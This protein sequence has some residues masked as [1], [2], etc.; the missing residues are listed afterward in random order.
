MIQ[1]RLTKSGQRRYRVRYE[2]PAG[3][4]A[5]RTFAR[6]ED[7]LVYE[8]FV[9]DRVRNGD[10]VIATREQRQRTVASY[11]EEAIRYR[12]LEART[13][14]RYLELWRLHVEPT[15]GRIPIAKVSPLDIRSWVRR[16]LTVGLAK[17][18][19]A[20]CVSVLSLAMN[21]AVE[22]GV[23]AENPTRGCRPKLDRIPPGRSLTSKGV[24]QLLSHLTVEDRPLYLLGS[25]CG[26]RFGELAGLQVGD[27]DVVTQRV[28]IQRA[29]I[30]LRGKQQVKPY[31]KGGSE[32][33]RDIGVP[34]Q[35]IVELEPLLQGRPEGDGSSPTDSAGPSGTRPHGIVFSRL[36]M[37]PAS[38][39]VP[40][41]CSAV[42]PPRS[43]FN[44]APASE[45]FRTF[46]A[47]PAHS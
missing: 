8:R 19:A 41:T 14:D 47:M 17:A 16:L 43:A 23:R 45:T 29:V 40:C 44:T 4:E 22:Q 37:P 11:W 30:E 25:I 2:T 34:R 26:L 36:W 10:L 28:F 1:V 6:K 42:P 31:P 9:K 35:V 32:A 33:R 39:A 3:R 13:R 46:S 27:I 15:W 18:T 21:E 5:T 24:A 38:P 20:Q 7:A 12:Q